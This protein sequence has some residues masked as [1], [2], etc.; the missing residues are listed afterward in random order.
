MS[1]APEIITG[2]KQF[3]AIDFPTSKG[4]LGDL[5]TTKPSDYITT[6]TTLGLTEDNAFSFGYNF[7]FTVY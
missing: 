7:S 5:T 1:A 2:I 6:P 3:L 4:F